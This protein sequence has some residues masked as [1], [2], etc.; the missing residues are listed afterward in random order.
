MKVTKVNFLKILGK[1]IIIKLGV[2]SSMVDETVILSTLLPAFTPYISMMKSKGIMDENDLI[3]LNLL[4]EALNTFFKVV[5]MLNFPFSNN[6]VSITKKD[7]D[8]F[9]TEVE[10]YG[11][12]D[13]VICLPCQN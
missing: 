9:L 12:I 13:E 7:A 10:K 2:S 4:E 11:I 3:N 8:N 1:H 6:T 5:P